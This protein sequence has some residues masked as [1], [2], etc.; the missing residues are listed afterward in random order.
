MTRR[1]LAWLALLVLG[2]LAIGAQ[3]QL[4]PR[5]FFAP[6]AAGPRLLPTAG[7]P[8]APG[9]GRIKEARP[10]AHASSH[11][12]PT[13]APQGQATA[14]PETMVVTG[15]PSVSPAFVDATLRRMASPLAGLG[16][17]IYL[18]GRRWDIDPVFLVAFAVYFDRA[19]A[20]PAA[21]HNVGHLRAVGAESAMEGYRV[22][23]TWR[24][25]IDAWYR[26]MR[27]LYIQQWNRRTLDAIVPLYAPAPRLGVEAELNDLRAMIAAWRAMAR[28]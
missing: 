13:S 19:G 4:I 11:M 14:L 15:P 26:L 21:A 17:Y 27:H 25:G 24:A 18:D 8:A 6:N 22:F 1:W 7:A 12:P 2:A 23:A 10:H 28:S 9:R 20:L 5:P 16:R 3:R